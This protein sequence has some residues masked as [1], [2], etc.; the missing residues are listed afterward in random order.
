MTQVVRLTAAKWA[1]LLRQAESAEGGDAFVTAVAEKLRAPVRGTLLAV[2]GDVGAATRLLLTGDRALLVTEPVA[3]RGGDIARSGD[4]QLSFVPVAELWPAIA[5]VLPPLEQLRA[6]AVAASRGREVA[7]AEPA[8][9]LLERE[10]ANLQ[11]RVEAWPGP[12]SPS[13]V[14][15]RLWSV[16]DGRLLDVRTADGRVRLMERPAGAVAAELE[17]AL[18]GALAEVRDSARPA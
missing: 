10:E 6:A 8:T 5:A 18:A 1:E 15:A 17:W 2:R 3:Q 7:T 11:V 9:A 12:E 13:R 4:V 14:W 16:V